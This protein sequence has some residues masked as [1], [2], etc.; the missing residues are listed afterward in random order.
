MF[1]VLAREMAVEAFGQFGFAFSL[2]TFVAI[3]AT[4]G[5]PVLVLRQVPVYQNTAQVELER[6]LVRDSWITV[7]IGG[8]VCAGLILIGSEIWGII[9]NRDVSF[10]SWTAFLTMAMAVARHQAF[11]LRAYDSIGLA[12]VPRDIIW[13]LAVIFCVWLFAGSDSL[14]SSRALLFCTVT[15][16]VILIGQMFSHRSIAPSTLLSSNVETD[17]KYWATESAGLWA[18][19]MAQAA[20]PNL[21]VVIL[22]F[23]LTPEETGPFFAA[24]KTAMLLTL[25]MTAGAMVGSPLISRYYHA[26]EIQD[27][28]KILSFLVLGVATPVFIGLGLIVLFG[29]H[30]LALLS[31]DFVTAKSV[32]IVLATGTF[33]TS[34]SGPAAYIMHMTGNHRVYLMIMIVTQ[35]SS[36]MLLPPATNYFGVMGAA[37][38]VAIGMLSW[39][40]WVWLWSRKN[41]GLDPTLFGVME[42]VIV[43]KSLSARGNRAS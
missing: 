27:L 37:A 6:G 31:P 33:L 42:Q 16:T 41:L 2:A 22:G 7:V 40:V 23:V 3:C 35:I 26:G 4:L 9:E 43:Q 13:R 18:A 15:L 25:P 24:L 11:T 10:L 1:V 34:L 39:N 17:R 12:L 38:V 21:S 20:G 14:S 36:L 28:Q 29:D 19:T 32:L 8:S 30:V 5:Q